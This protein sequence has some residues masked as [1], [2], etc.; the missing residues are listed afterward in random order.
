M[1]REKLE[2][3]FG[4]AKLV[5]ACYGIFAS[6]R[7][8]TKSIGDIRA[9]RAR[10]RPRI[11]KGTGYGGRQVRYV[12]VGDMTSDEVLSYLKKVKPE[13]ESTKGET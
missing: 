1:D 2:T 5:I 13:F 3:V 4:Y 11:T 10:R 9:I 6:I 7:N 8:F 12:D